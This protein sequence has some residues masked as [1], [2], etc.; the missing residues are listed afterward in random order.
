MASWLDVRR[1]ALALPEATEEQKRGY[2][3]WSVHKKGFAWER[4]LRKTDITQLRA[5]GHQVPKGDILA[6]MIDHVESREAMIAE[7]PHILF[8][9]PHFDDYP[10]VLVRLHRATVGEIDDLLED[11]WLLCAPE[12][13]AAVHLSG[14]E[15]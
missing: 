14:R 12:R 15:R 1:I 5:L 7:N 6:V 10:A 4:P 3:S 2:P 8:T 11:A 9:V 13:L